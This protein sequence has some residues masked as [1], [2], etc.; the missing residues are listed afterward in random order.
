M[1]Q[2][3]PIDHKAAAANVYKDVFLD[4]LTVLNSKITLFRQTFMD[5]QPR[6]VGQS[7]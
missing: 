1:F 5:K 3:E 6:R 2:L 7:V 4:K